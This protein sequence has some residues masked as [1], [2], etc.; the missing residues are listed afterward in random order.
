MPT[1]LQ[2]GDELPSVTRTMTR[3]WIMRH[4]LALLS[5][6]VDQ[7]LGE[8]DVVNIHTSQEFARRNALPAPVPDG[9]VTG[10]WISSLMLLHFGHA[11]ARGGTLDVKFIKP[12]FEGDELTVRARLAERVAESGATRLRFDV[13]CERPEG[14]VVTTGDASVLLTH[15]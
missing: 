13:W 4:D 7:R 15:D 5:C 2:V 10:N 6:R 14:Q 3:D 11:Y 12:T 9:M 1:D 8:K